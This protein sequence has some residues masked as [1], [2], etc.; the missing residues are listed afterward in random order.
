MVIELVVDPMAAVFGASD[1]IAGALTVNALPAEAIVP[2]LTV[3]LKA[4]AAVIAVAGTV[5]VMAVAVPVSTVKAVLP[6]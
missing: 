2:F 1:A 5:A 6:R 3:T 4:A